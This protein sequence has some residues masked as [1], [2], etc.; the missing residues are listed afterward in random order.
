MVMKMDLMMDKLRVL[1]M[2]RKLDQSKD[3]LMEN[4]WDIQKVD[5]LDLQKGQQ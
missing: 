5:K 4:T 1:L 2:G 3:M